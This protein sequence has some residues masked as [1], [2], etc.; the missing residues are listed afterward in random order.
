[1]IGSFF[2]G[3]LSASPPLQMDTIDGRNLAPVGSLSQYLLFFL[4]HPRWFFRRISEPST[5]DQE[6]FKDL[7]F[8]NHLFS[9][10]HI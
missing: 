9:N 1:M 3:V 4:K 7:P 6:I 8:P 10:K 5:V 2:W